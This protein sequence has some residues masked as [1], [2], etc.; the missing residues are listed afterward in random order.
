MVQMFTLNETGNAMTLFTHH[1]M[2]HDVDAVTGRIIDPNG[3]LV[4]PLRINYRDRDADREMLNEYIPLMQYGD[5]HSDLLLAMDLLEDQFNTANDRYIEYQRNN[6]TP[7]SEP[8]TAFV[9]P[10]SEQ[11]N[12]KVVHKSLAIKKSTSLSM[13]Q[14]EWDS[15]S[16]HHFIGTDKYFI[17]GSFV[18]SSMKVQVANG[19][20]CTTEGY[21]VLNHTILTR[22]LTSV[23][24]SRYFSPLAS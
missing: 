5:R 2:T 13:I 24:S 20:T 12:A 19:E 4:C 3:G 8:V 23:R 16:S 9:Y 11:G 18:N 6:G 22:L 21:G 7:P 15:D 10:T 1:T 17:P 14:F